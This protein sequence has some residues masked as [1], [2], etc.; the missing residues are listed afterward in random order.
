M[1]PHSLKL[2]FQL[3][4]KI[5]KIKSAHSYVSH[6]SFR[7]IRSHKKQQALFLVFLYDPAQLCLGIIIVGSRLNLGHYMQDK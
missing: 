4:K 7:S 5:A 2:K 6:S 1:S 3:L